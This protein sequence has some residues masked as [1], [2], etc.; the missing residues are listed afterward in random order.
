M[1]QMNDKQWET[2]EQFA[3]RNYFTIVNR[4]KSEDGEH[5]YVATHPDLP[6]C[7]ADGQTP[8][9]AKLELANT[10]V[11]YFYFLL[12]DNLPIPEPRT[13]EVTSKYKPV[14]VY[15][16]NILR[17]QPIPSSGYVVGELELSPV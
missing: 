14:E 1:I 2:A 4:E 7:V 12:E 11:D 3:A 9:E 5:Y 8:E 15:S 6:G 10:R 13:Y 16:D 17:E